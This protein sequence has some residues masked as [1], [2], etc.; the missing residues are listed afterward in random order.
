MHAEGNSDVEGHAGQPALGAFC[1][2]VFL[3]NL[4]GAGMVSDAIP[5]CLELTHRLWS[6]TSTVIGALCIIHT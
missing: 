1:I 4:S 6:T 2:I 5:H 3:L